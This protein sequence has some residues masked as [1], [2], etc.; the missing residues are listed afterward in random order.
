MNRRDTAFVLAG[1]AV[2]ALGSLAWSMRPVLQLGPT[3]AHE[4]MRSNGGAVFDIRT[5]RLL[6]IHGAATGMNLT[7]ERPTNA[8]ATKTLAREHRP[9]SPGQSVE[10]PAKIG[11]MPEN[12]PASPASAAWSIS[13]PAGIR[14]S[15]SALSSRTTLGFRMPPMVMV[16]VSADKPAGAQ[17]VGA[18]GSRSATAGRS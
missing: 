6:S 3:P 4:L 13:I 10:G 11:L 16:V 17:P 12:A 5:N 9:N 15:V 7:I 1:V 14:A 18:Y 2:G 8:A